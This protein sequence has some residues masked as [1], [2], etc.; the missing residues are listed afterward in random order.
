MKKVFLSLCMLL[1]CLPVWGFDAYF[2]NST[3]NTPVHSVPGVVSISFDA[4]S[5]VVRRA[6]FTSAELDNS[7]FSHMLFRDKSTSGMADVE[8]PATA[9]NVLVDGPMLTVSASGAIESV[10][11]TSVSGALCGEASSASS[12]LSY[13][14]SGLSAGVYIVQVCSG[15]QV[16]VSKIIKK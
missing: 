4:A 10:R 12:T 15:S 16:S 5:T 3:S 1:P 8:L 11:L 9:V 14:M 2:Y 7:T 13:D 6:D